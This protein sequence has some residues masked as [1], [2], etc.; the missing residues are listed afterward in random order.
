M[1]RS[2]PAVR[3]ALLLPPAMSGDTI[4]FVPIEIRDYQPADEQD[5][6]RCRVLSFL[7]TAYFDDVMT[8][9]KSPGVGAEPVAVG[10][11]V[12]VGCLTCPWTARWPRSTRS[13]CT[14]DYRRQGI[15]ARLF[16]LASRRAAALGASVIEAWTRK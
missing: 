14:Q 1:R 3:G 2:E 16:E 13:A 10:S 4:G 12:V 7:N 8:A 11:P 6:L 15:G 5:W 9:K